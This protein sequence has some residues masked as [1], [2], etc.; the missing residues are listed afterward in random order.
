MRA[1]ERKRPWKKDDAV[2]GIVR[3]CARVTQNG[4]KGRAGLQR[5]WSLKP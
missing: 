5:A 4:A 3:I 2:A 1:K